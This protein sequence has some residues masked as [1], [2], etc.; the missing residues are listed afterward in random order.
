M[1]NNKYT[2]TD[3]DKESI[4]NLLK[5]KLSHRPEILFAY[6][7]GSFLLPTTCGDVDL[8][9]YLDEKALP[10][11]HWE[12]E[13]ELSMCL[14]Q[15]VGIP[16]DIMTLNYAPVTLRY[17]VSSGKVLLSRDE[18]ARFD[19]LEQTWREYFDYQPVFQAFLKDLLSN[20]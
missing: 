1:R 13:A 16:V 20:R 12:Y 18:K 7:H 9:V 8:A 11:K 10:Q 19:F 3:L 15:Y 5:S 14:D 2:L 17:H 4:E 6:L